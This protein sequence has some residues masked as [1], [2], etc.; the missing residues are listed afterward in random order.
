[1][2][3]SLPALCLAATLPAAASARTAAVLDYPGAVQTFAIAINN[4]RVI[5]G[6]FIDSAGVAHAFARSRSG[7][8]A[9]LDPAGPIGTSAVS[10]ALSVNNRGEIA[11]FFGDS[12]GARHGFVLRGGTVQQIDVP[13]AEKTYAY[14]I[15]DRNEIIGVWFDANGSQHAWRMAAGG[16]VSADIPGPGI[17]TPYSINDRSQ[18]AGEYQDT[19]PAAGHGYVQDASG[20]V[21]FVDAPGA[22]PD[23]TFLISINNGGVRLGGYVATDGSVVNF[24]E[25]GSRFR[26]FTL[27]AQLGA[28]GI[29]VETL[30]D[31][32]DVVGYYADA[33]GNGHGFLSVP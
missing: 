28:N 5:V 29:T 31:N 8:Y 14:G 26:P 18:I 13:G 20:R 4:A 19:P 1:M 15:N 9:V 10:A 27:P 33:A 25:S 17:T 2:K 7:I 12:A 30:N 21:R 23:S 24:L 6:Q 22:P 3:L 32:A 16:M 11:G